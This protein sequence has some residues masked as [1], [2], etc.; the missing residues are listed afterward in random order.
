MQF[1]AKTEREPRRRSLSTQCIL[2]HTIQ[3]LYTD[4]LKTKQFVNIRQIKKH[5]KHLNF[6]AK[7]SYYYYLQLKITQKV[8][9]CFLLVRSRINYEG[10]SPVSWTM[11]RYSGTRKNFFVCLSVRLRISQTSL[12][13]VKHKRNSNSKLEF[14]VSFVMQLSEK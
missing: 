6:R 11:W 1:V 14:L 3:K 12:P 7:N 10:S 2:K 13:L 8:R 5:N 9:N 4:S